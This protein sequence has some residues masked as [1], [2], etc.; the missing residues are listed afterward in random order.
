MTRKAFTLVELL[1]ANVLAALLIVAIL[2][3]IGALGRDRRAHAALDHDRT[4][5]TT[6]DNLRRLI[7]WDFSNA[8]RWRLVDG[9]YFFQSHGSLDPQT[10]VPTTLPVTVR[11]EL[12]E[13]AGKRWLTR[14]QTPRDKTADGAWSAPL[15]ADVADLA[16]A[17]ADNGLAP[18]QSVWQNL[19]S[20]VRLTL[21]WTD[22]KRPV[23]NETL[24]H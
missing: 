8:T 13:S 21:T 5:Q 15:C 1:A 9:A 18:P 6:N 23:L 19:P 12:N 20:Q 4:T 2:T 7:Q 16:L 14:S 11:Y 10:L 3:I 22:P 17:S 24:T